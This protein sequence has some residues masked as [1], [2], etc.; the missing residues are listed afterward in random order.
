LTEPILGLSFQTLFDAVFEA[1]LLADESGHIILANPAAQ[2][3]FS[4]SEQDIC[5]LNIEAL[6]PSRFREHHQVHRNAYNHNPKKR[7]MSNGKSLSLLRSD[8]MELMVDISLTPLKTS[9]H[10]YILVT[11]CPSDRRKAAEEAFRA[12]EERLKLATQAADLAIFD[13]DL[14]HNVFHW[15]DG[16][17]ML[18]GSEGNKLV[19]SK[20]FSA[21][22]HPDDRKSWQTALDAAADPANN[23][24][25]SSE[26]RVVNP[27]NGSE[28][29]VSA[30][31]RMHFE[32]GH[33]TQLIGVAKN[34]SDQKIFEKKQQEQ[35]NENEV[36]FKQQ[37]AA[38]TI[39]AI[40]HEINQPLSAISAYSE[41][42][43]R[44]MNGSDIYPDNLKRALEGCFHQAQRAGKSLHELIEFLH[45]TDL[46]SEPF[47]INEVIKE[48]LNIAKDDGFGGFHLELQ[49]E[50]DMPSVIA[51]SVQIKKVIV[52]LI[53]NAVEA[54]RA[55]GI[56]DSKITVTVQ[57]N[58]GINMAHISVK[59]CGPGL[60]LDKQNS[61]FKPFFTTKPSGIGMGL[62]ISRAL[63]EANSGELWFESNPDE[64]AIF[65]FT[66]PIAT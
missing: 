44:A 36:I 26:Y 39:S 51:N 48:A 30:I 4:Y 33:A 31:G 22:I 46:V 49:L 1:M 7:S 45:K 27:I 59:D 14:N 55:A 40:A 53:R 9:D 29:W 61:I 16:M 6:M 25:Y 50:K 11:L 15:D 8:G 37:V 64:G 19:S 24:E 54:M 65:H 63:I 42:A 3:L 17:G 35:R 23:G 10:L 38:Q 12:G 18:W 34:I 43:L 66:L 28:R 52:N 41:V 47:D 32:N 20:Q 21:A 58:K 2:K 56:E 60:D 13:F 62:T 5:K 57:T